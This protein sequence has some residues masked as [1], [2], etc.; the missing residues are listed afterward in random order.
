MIPLRFV[1]A[2]AF[3]AAAVLVACSK[4]IPGVTY[5][6]RTVEIPVAGMTCTGCE[7]TIGSTVLALEGVQACE[8]SF[9]DQRVRV[10]Y[11]I[12]L[13]DE[14]KIAEAIR[15]VGYE[16]PASGDAKPTNPH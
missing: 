1:I 15:S 12:G 16:I 6:M 14:T 5:A 10:T 3:F 7:G 9:A 2:P 8:A 13:T 11:A 4:E